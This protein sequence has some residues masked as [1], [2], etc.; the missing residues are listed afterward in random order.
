VV[1]GVVWFVDAVLVVVDVA[2]WVCW[3]VVGDVVVGSIVVSGNWSS[4]GVVRGVYSIVGGSRDVVGF[5][6]VVGG[7]LLRL[8]LPLKFL[9]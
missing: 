9:S 1:V 8:L 2:S 6:G 3:D 7:V 5:G 4:G